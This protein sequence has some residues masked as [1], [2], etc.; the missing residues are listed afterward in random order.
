MF[1]PSQHVGTRWEMCF[2]PRVARS[3]RQF[4]GKNE[5]NFQFRHYF[6]SNFLHSNVHVLCIWLV[7]TLKGGGQLPRGGECPLPPPLNETLNETLNG[8]QILVLRGYVLVL[9][10]INMKVYPRI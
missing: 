5:Q 10:K 8:K 3:L 2:L 7:A 6:H 4:M 9:D 1:N